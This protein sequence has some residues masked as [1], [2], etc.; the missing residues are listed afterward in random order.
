[1]RPGGYFAICGLPAD[2]DVLATAEAEGRRSGE[3]RIRATAGRMTRRDFTLGTTTSAT[4]TASGV[5]R[6]ADGRPVGGAIVLVP[7]TE[8]RTTTAED[9]R[10]TLAGLPSGTYP[11]EA[12]AIG[13]QPASVPVALSARRVA[14]A[15]VVL[16][17]RVTSLET[18]HVLGRGSRTLRAQQGFIERMQH[19]GSGKFVTAQQIERMGAT[20]SSDALQGIP[21]IVVAYRGTPPAT[22]DGPQRQVW[23]QA[24]MGRGYC[25]PDVYIDGFRIEGGAIDLD[26]LVTPQNV[27]GYEVYRSAASAPAQFTPTTAT[28]CGVILVW[29][30][31]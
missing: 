12:R 2:D 8:T 15:D 23:M 9:G 3:L 22:T 16:G 4:A 29:S 13:F 18:V 6:H 10:F 31:P 28:F 11:V 20:T 19:G 5:V 30:K 27:L 7:G 26:V 21:G 25:K 17:P 1:V 24:P 14:S